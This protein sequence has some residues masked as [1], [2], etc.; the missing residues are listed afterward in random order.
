ML[1]AQTFYKTLPDI[2]KI[3]VVRVNGLGDYLF[4]VPLSHCYYEI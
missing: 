1:S 2:Q 3:A 4:I